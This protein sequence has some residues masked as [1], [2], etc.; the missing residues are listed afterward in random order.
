MGC[1]FKP[2]S[3]RYIVGYMLSNLVL[4]ASSCKTR[5]PTVHLIKYLPKWKFWIWLS[6][7][8]CISAVS[9]QIGA[10]QAAC[11][12]TKCDVIKDVKL[13][14]MVYRR[15]YCH[16]FW[17]LSKQM[18]CYKFKWVRISIWAAT[19][20]FKK[21]IMCD[22]SHVAAHLLPQVNLK[23]SSSRVSEMSNITLQ[24]KYPFILKIFTMYLVAKIKPN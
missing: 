23:I 9:S 3:R 7:F 15:I 10:M 14:Q 19:W 8:W 4:R 16:N 18:S 6:P 21:K 12:P 24:P 20:D 5:F 13:F 11:H 17:T 2:H 1:G 22:Q